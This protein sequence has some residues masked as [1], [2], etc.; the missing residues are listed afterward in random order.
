MDIIKYYFLGIVLLAVVGVIGGTTA[1]IVKGKTKHYSIQY[2]C[3][4]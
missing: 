1:G 4:K 2:N 3:L